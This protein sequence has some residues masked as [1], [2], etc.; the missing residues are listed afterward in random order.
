M[1]DPKPRRSARL[2]N[3]LQPGF[4]PD[5][6]SSACSDALSDGID[7]EDETTDTTN[8]ASSE[9]VLFDSN[10]EHLPSPRKRV[11]LCKE[12]TTSKGAARGPISRTHGAPLRADKAG[13]DMVDQARTGLALFTSGIEKAFEERDE[14]IEWQETRIA[15]LESEL[16]KTRVALQNEESK[17]HAREEEEQNRL[18][19]LET[20]LLLMKAAHL[21]QKEEAEASKTRASD[22]RYQLTNAEI[23]R[24]FYKSGMD[25]AEDKFA[26]MKALIGSC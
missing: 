15:E 22:L 14:Q 2:R 18:K 9:E 19:G 7:S 11:R 16:G 8:D 17:T 1:Q 25:K 20:Q 3:R 24:D 26:K 6:S 13:D 12:C 5:E 4:N 10:V 23:A 21:R